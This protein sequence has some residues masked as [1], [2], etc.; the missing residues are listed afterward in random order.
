MDLAVE[1]VG[2]AVELVGLAVELVGLAVEF[3]GSGA[4]LVGL[5]G[6]KGLVERVVKEGSSSW[7][8]AARAL[9]HSGLV[10]PLA[11]RRLTVARNPGVLKIQ[12][13]K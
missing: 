9:L 4:S 2:L 3:R 6:L 1:L 5:A 13:E 12:V 11:M 7:N 8:R 10:S